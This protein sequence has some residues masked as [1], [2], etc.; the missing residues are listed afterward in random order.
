MRC[1]C[2]GRGQVHS[3]QLQTGLQAA[4]AGALERRSR[5]GP[6]VGGAQRRR[7]TVRVLRAV[8]A[9]DGWRPG[10]RETLQ[11]PHEPASLVKIQLGQNA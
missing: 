9:G 10:D 4:G 7:D 5:L 11:A 1:V 2:L 3:D 6:W 8:L